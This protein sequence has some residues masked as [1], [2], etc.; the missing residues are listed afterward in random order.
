M[1]YLV[2]IFL[3]SIVG[4]SDRDQADNDSLDS[5]I[6]KIDSRIYNEAVPI[7]YGWKFRVG[8]D[9]NWAQTNFD[10]AEWNHLPSDYSDLYDIDGIPQ[11]PS[12]IWLRIHVQLMDSVP[13]TLIANI[14]QSGASEIFVNGKRIYQFGKV[15]SDPDLVDSYNPKAERIFLQLKHE[16]FNVIAVRFANNPNRFPVF[17]VYPK[18]FF[19]IHVTSLMGDRYLTDLPRIAGQFMEVRGSAMLLFILYFVFFIFFP[20]QKISLYFAIAM[21]FYSVYLWIMVQVQTRMRYLLSTN[22]L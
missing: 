17:H 2:L 4:I 20:R 18:S 12:I 9:L 10:D 15:N 6:F 16:Q 19:S 5:A 14:F 22:F 7:D 21:L 8:D 11:Q 13:A 3:V 1:K